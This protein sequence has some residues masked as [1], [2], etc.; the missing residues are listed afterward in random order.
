MTAGLEVPGGLAAAARLRQATV[1]DRSPATGTCTLKIMDDDQVHD[2]VL[3]G[4]H[5]VPRVDDTVWCVQSGPVWLIVAGQKT[6]LP[7][8]RIQ[9]GDTTTTTAGAPSKVVFDFG[10]G[11]ANIDTDQM[12]DLAGDAIAINWPGV[13]LLGMQ[14]RHE[15]TSAGA[16]RRVADICRNGLAANQT[17]VRAETSAGGAEQF[18]SSVL[19][20]CD[21]GDVIQLAVF[22]GNPGEPDVAWGDGSYWTK[23][24]AAWQSP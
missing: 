5:Y 8:C 1:V 20:D 15:G 3:P 21:A 24:W 6:R 23:L 7:V 11:A 16:C 13:Y 17:E 10:A 9:T 18:S 22:G 19:V 14:V 4:A 12:A 2:E